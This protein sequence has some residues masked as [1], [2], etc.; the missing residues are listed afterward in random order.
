MGFIPL[1]KETEAKYPSR[2]CVSVINRNIQKKKIW[3]LQRKYSVTKPTKDAFETLN[4]VNYK[5]VRTN[6]ML[7]LEEISNKL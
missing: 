4:P 7:A 3:Q 5:T 1:Q 2:F 6:K